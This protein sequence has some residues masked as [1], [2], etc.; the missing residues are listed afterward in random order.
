MRPLIA[1]QPRDARSLHGRLPIIPYGKYWAACEQRSCG[2]WA[3]NDA[4][5]GEIEVVMEFG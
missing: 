3:F 5:V 1:R 4:I 2:G